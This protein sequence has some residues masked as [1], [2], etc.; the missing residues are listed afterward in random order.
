MAV[1]K[2]T[3]ICRITHYRNVPW[4]LDHGIH[5]RTSPTND[6]N[7]INIGHG[8]VI[9]KRALRLVRTGPGG[10][11][12]DYVPFYFSTHSVM[13]YNI[14]TGRVEGVSV[15]QEEIVFIVSSIEKLG[16]LK[17]PF[18]YSDG[19]ALA[20]NTVFFTNI[21][22]LEKLDWATIQSQDFKRRMNDLDRTRRYQAECLVHRHVPLEALLGIGC[23]DQ[24]RVNLLQ[25]EVTSRGLSVKIRLCPKWYF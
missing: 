20:A 12:N 2:P 23:K 16:E 8:E 21:A 9:G 24:E 15:R 25:Q 5:C 4:V 1:P 7:F 18:V 22:D 3:L 11:L 10:F 6:P 14:H 19:H 13:L 17:L